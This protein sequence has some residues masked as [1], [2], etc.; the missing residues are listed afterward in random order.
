M[1]NILL[2]GSGG[3]IGSHLKKWLNEYNLFCPRSSELDLMDGL[4]V[5]KYVESNNI[6]Y[7]VHSAYLKSKQEIIC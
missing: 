2:T 1:K 4:A 5:K 7:I 3:F 6:N